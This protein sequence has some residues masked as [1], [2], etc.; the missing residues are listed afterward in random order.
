MTLECLIFWCQRKK[1]THFFHL[2][3]IHSR[4]SGPSL[5]H[6]FVSYKRRKENK[7]KYKTRILL[8]VTNTALLY[9]HNFLCLFY[10]YCYLTLI[11]ISLPTETKSIML[12]RMSSFVAHCLLYAYLPLRQ[13]IILQVLY[14]QTRTI[15][16][17]TL[18]STTYRCQ[19]IIVI[20]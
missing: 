6:L 10:K 16:V 5:C 7:L 17:Y 14:T 11:K 9:R 20:L 13:I 2:I 3:F 1:K 4:K 15:H 19:T 18:L 12:G 8:S